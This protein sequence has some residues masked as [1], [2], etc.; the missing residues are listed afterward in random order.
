MV[1][2]YG[3]YSSVA[4]GIR[5]KADIDDKIPC[6]LEPGLAGKAIRKNWAELIQKIYEIDP[7]T[8]P[9]CRGRMSV[10]AFIHDQDVIRKIPTHL[11]LWDVKRK[12]PSRAPPIDDFPAYDDQQGP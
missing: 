9:A 12:P 11:N 10:I 8:C 2:Y 5:K 6:I 4:R 3:Y 7:L 1:R